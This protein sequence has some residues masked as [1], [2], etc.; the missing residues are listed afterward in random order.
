MAPPGVPVFQLLAGFAS[1]LGN[2]PVTYTDITYALRSFDVS[3]QSTRQQGPIYQWQPGTLRAVLKNDTGN[4][5]PDNL[6][7]PYV[8]TTGLQVLTTSFSMAGPGTW[9]APANLV[10]TIDVICVG[11]GGGGGGSSVA[12]FLPGGGGGG[13]GEY[14]EEKTLVVTA[15]NSYAYTVGSAGAGGVAGSNGVNATATTFAGDAVTVTANG[16]QGGGHGTASGGVTTGGAGGPGGTGS[17]NTI[18]N[19]GG[20]GGAGD[21]TGQGG[22]GGSCGGSASAGNV[23]WIGG[24]AQPGAGGVPV[25]PWTGDQGRGGGWDPGGVHTIGFQPGGG[26]V[27]GW[28]EGGGAAGGTGYITITY[29]VAV[30]AQ[31]TTEVTGNVPVQLNAWWPAANTG[32]FANL[33]TAYSDGWQDSGRYVPGYAETTLTATDA[34]KLLSRS[35]LPQIAAVGAGE[36]SGARITRILNAA[37]W[38]PALVNVTA[39]DTVL[40]GETFGDYALNRLQVTNDTEGG[41]FYIDAGGAAF[42]RRRNGLLRDFRSIYPTA[43]FSDQPNGPGPSGSSRNWDFEDGTVQSWTGINATVA[44]DTTWAYGPGALRSLLV[45]SASSAA[46]AGYWQAVSPA[47]PVI[48]GELHGAEVTL[49]STAN[50]LFQVTVQINWHDASDNYVSTSAFP[51]PTALGTPQSTPGALHLSLQGQRVP[52]GVFNAHVV[53]IDQEGSA[54]GVQFWVDYV[55]WDPVL[56]YTALGRANDMTTLANDIQFTRPGG[57]LQEAKSLPA[58]AQNRGVITY[59]RSDLM[60]NSDTDALNAAKWVLSLSLSTEDRIDSLEL[61]PRNDPYGI[62]PHVLTRRI[63]DRIRVIRNPPNLITPLIRDLYITGIDIAF[64]YD[65]AHFTVTWHA[66][67]VAKYGAYIILD[68]TFAGRTDFG[69]LAFLCQGQASNRSRPAT[70]SP[71]QISTRG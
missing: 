26:G 2:Y 46:G 44:N 8:S 59:Q 5:D 51:P 66:R 35:F 15:G 38:P 9:A 58:I 22:G 70:S 14:A 16:G 64:D 55:L 53:V 41:E 11:G 20:L 47:I 71:P 45:T 13:G 29:T 50:S 12:S 19:A 65:T 40:Q 43:V 67:D 52:Q 18:H 4:F 34:M 23:G 60:F 69:M 36:D 3:R 27:G 48:P 30:P 33:I 31:A 56:K 6:H 25:P 1:Y 37:G 54:A 10:G 57:T 63:G 28:S 21:A 17:T 61:A 7:G 32:I 68:D 39:G 42:F 24:A 49:Y 62:I